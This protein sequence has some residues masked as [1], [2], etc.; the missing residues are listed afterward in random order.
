MI[1]LNMKQ[2]PRESLKDL[3]ELIA[4]EEKYQFE[5]FS[6]SDAIALAKVMVKNAEEL[7]RPV[8]IRIDLNGCTVF[9]YLP[10]GTG[11]INEMWMEKKVGIVMALRWSTMRFW[12][13]QE[14]VEGIK[15]NPE[16]FPAALIVPCGGGFP[17]TVKGCG[18]VG[19]IAVSAL[20]DQAEHDFIIDSLEG[21]RDWQDRPAV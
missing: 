7:G 19:A 13:W 8:S 4:Q 17:I 2:S 15:R 18:V 11:K 20:G 14:S 21:F 10:E 12:A 6:A 16:M 9:Q 3:D 5:T 1:D